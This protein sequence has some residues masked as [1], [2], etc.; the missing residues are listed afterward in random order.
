[1]PPAA[2]EPV[3]KSAAYPRRRISGIPI[4]P[5]A[6]HVAGDEPVS[7]ENKAHAPIF[8]ITND[9]GTLYNQRF[10]ASYKSLPAREEATAAPMMMNIGIDASVKS[11]S[12]EKTVSAMYITELKPSDQ[13]MKI[14]AVLPNAKAIGI[15]VASNSN[16]TAKIRPPS[17]N[18]VIPSPSFYF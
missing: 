15:P 2:M 6:A 14:S 13:S 4:L 18:G 10:K 9:P 1:M 8:E 12:P 16:A 5:I 17:I 11:S 3:A 7:A